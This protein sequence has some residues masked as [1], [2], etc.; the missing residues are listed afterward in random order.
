MELLFVRHAESEPNVAGLISSLP[1]NPSPLTPR[2]RRQA[3]ALGKR[4]GDEPLDLCVT[5]EL[6]RSVT[7][8][9]IA[10][11]AATSPAWSSRT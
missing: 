7:T 3:E 2:G 11:G 9:E 5:S 8:T 10:L 6:E 4:L 1:S